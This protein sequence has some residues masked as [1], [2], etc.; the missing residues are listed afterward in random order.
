MMIPL[1]GFLSSDTLGMVI[2]A[3]ENDTIAKLAWRLQQAASVR[4]KPSANFR[5]E[6][7]GNIL[8]KDTTVQRAQMKPL[9]RF[10]VIIEETETRLNERET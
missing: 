10:D 2:L 4:I 7:R 3:E 1:Y 5:V 9:T 6:Y 8:S